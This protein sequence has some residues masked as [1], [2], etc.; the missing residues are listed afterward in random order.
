M[1]LLLDTHALVWW[2][3]DDPRLPAAAR[4]AIAGPGNIV[5]VS[6]V[7]AWEIAT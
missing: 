3:T 7:S 1:K 5:H 4:A 2:W 6:A